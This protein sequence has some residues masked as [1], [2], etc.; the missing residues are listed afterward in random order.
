MSEPFKRRWTT[1]GTVAVGHNVIGLVSA[2][3]WSSI[4]LVSVSLINAI[5]LVCIAPGNA[6]GIVALAGGTAIGGS[7]RSAMPI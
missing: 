2:R 1:I 4:G 5:G 3:L 6:M 7:N